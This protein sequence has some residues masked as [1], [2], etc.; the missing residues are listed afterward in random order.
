[1]RQWP[2]LFPDFRG[3]SRSLAHDSILSKIRVSGKA[4]AVH[5]KKSK[6]TYCFELNYGNNIL[7]YDPALTKMVRQR[8]QSYIAS[9]IPVCTDTVQGRVWH[10]S[11]WNKVIT[12]LGPVL[13][14]MGPKANASSSLWQSA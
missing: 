12:V 7:S 9:S 4:G 2:P 11:L 3:I 13:K 1:M 8:Q 14:C 6:T 5:F 10:R